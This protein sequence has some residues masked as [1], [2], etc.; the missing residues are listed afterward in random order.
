RREIAAAAD[1]LRQARK[2]LILAGGGVHYALATERLAAFALGRRLPVAETIA[3]RG[4][5]RHDHTMNVGPIGVIGAASAN[6]LAAEADVVL[7]IGTRLQDFT[8][9]SWTVFQDPEVRLVSINVARFD[10]VKHLA[11]AVV[12]DA[13]EALAELDAALGEHLP[14]EG[15]RRRAAALYGEW[16]ATIEART[17]ATNTDLPSYAQVVG[18]VNRQAGERDRVLTAA[19]GLPGEL[20]KNWKVKSPGTFDCEFG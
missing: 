15:W 18:A 17:R 5:L 3:G 4:A 11:L 14:P 7:A 12:G 6:A 1:L 16:N 10:A 8:T 2:P 9:G 19:G 13:D 20:T